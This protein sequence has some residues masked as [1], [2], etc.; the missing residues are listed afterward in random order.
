M[1]DIKRAVIW[2]AVSSAKQAE[3]DKISL[4][5]QEQEARAWC[6]DKGYEVLEVLAVRG[7]SRSD[8]NIVR[9]L[10]EYDAK[11]VTA[12]ARLQT[13]WETKGFDALVA[14][15]SDRFGRSSTLINWVIE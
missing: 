12:Y 9:M 15:S 2:V 8:P 5:Y 13:L 14:Y 6:A 11:G 1:A 10:E 4:G 7:H 3:E